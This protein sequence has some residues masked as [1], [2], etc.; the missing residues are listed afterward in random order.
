MAEAFTL[1]QELLNLHDANYSI[2]NEIFVADLSKEELDEMLNVIEDKLGEDSYSITNEE[3]FDVIRRLK[4][5]YDALIEDLNNDNEE[6]FDDHKKTLEIYGFL[7]FWL[8]T[9][10]ENKINSKIG[11]TGS[12]ETTNVSAA[13]KTKSKSKQPRPKQSRPKSSS[14]VNANSY[15]WDW[16][17]QKEEAL[18]LMKKILGSRIKRTAYKM[19][20]N[21]N[22]IKATSIKNLI[23][24][25]ISISVKDYNH[26]FDAKTYII[27]NLQYYDFLSD[28][29]AELLQVLVEQYDNT[30]L[31]EDVLIEISNKEFTS[32]D[33]N[34]VSKSFSKFLIK[35]SELIPNLVMKQISILVIQLDSESY[36]MRSCLM[37]TLGNLITYLVNNEDDMQLNQSQVNSFF[38]ALEERFLD[39]NAL[40]RSRLLQAKFP[41][42]RQTLTDLVV[43]SLEDKSCHVRRNSIK[44]LTTLITTHPYGVIHGE[45]NNDVIMTDSN[46]QTISRDDFARLQLTRRYYADAIRFI[47][48][49][50]TA[51]PTL[52][53]LLAS[54]TKSEVLETIVF[55]ETAHT[56]K[57]E[58][59]SEGISK[60]L[61]LIWTNDNNDEGKGVKN[62]LVESYI[63]MYLETTEMISP[64]E[65]ANQITKNLIS[66]TINAT[67]AELTSLE[68]LLSIIMNEK[69]AISEEVIAKLWSVYS[70]QKDIP[71]SRRRGA[72]IIL[73]MLANGKIDIVKEKID[74]LLKIGL[75]PLGKADLILAK[76]T[77]IA[78]QCLAENKK[79]VK[80]KDL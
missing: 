9:D 10:V 51:I 17:C 26:G 46:Q 56:Y 60:M 39:V 29:M 78:L 52:C 20:G 72:I 49:I 61:H 31:V 63:K 18:S 45:R 75:G 34:N 5:E 21:V 7:L 33:N 59:A 13:K 44:L 28:S 66:L 19:L 53:Q 73:S 14:S 37:E 11:V 43:R 41:K 47:N 25:I 57:M 68:Q 42:R 15:E 24:E 58:F 3:I 23:Y 36:I 12:L 32:Q 48:Q 67:L 22:N 76:Y 80:G 65:K 8:I 1:H 71:K 62:R 6:N 50:H 27:Q 40:C 35:L 77:C 79:K 30:Q 38:D 64:A 69:D 2:S 4:S 16:N 54:T 55:F 74:L 70:T